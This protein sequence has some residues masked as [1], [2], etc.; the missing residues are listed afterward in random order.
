MGTAPRISPSLFEIY[1]STHQWVYATHLLTVSKK[2]MSTLEGQSELR[3]NCHTGPNAQSGAER[4]MPRRAKS[5]TLELAGT[6]A[7]LGR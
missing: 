6:S 3:C 4:F 7:A 1:T 5:Q 2:G